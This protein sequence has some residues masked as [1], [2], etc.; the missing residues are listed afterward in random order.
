VAIVNGTTNGETLNGTQ[1]ADVISG[2]GGN[3]WLYGNGGNDTIYAHSAG[4]TSFYNGNARIW[5]GAGDDRIYLG[6][7]NVTN[8]AYGEQGADYIEGLS[9]NDVIDGGSENDVIFGGGGADSLYGGTGDDDITMG[10]GSSTSPSIV[11]G[12]YGNDEM[13]LGYSGN[14]TARGGQGDD[15]FYVKQPSWGAASY[16]GGT[17]Y[18]E[19]IAQASNIS[20]GIRAIT[21]V[22]K[23][24]A[25]INTGV[26]I[27]AYAGSTPLDFTAVN[28][29]GIV[30]INGSS[31]DN[32]VIYLAGKNAGVDDFGLGRED[33]VNAGGGDDTIYGGYLDDLLNGDAGN[34]L[35]YGDEGDDVISAG[36][37]LDGVSGGDGLDILTGGAGADKFIFSA[38]HDTDTVTDFSVTE[39]DEL[40]SL[41]G[42]VGIDDFT[43][44]AAITSQSGADTIIDFGNGDVL[45]LTGVTASSLTAS[46]FEF[47]V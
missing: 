4:Y 28:L 24:T 12:G 45:T 39:T 5:G 17:E 11:D 10:Y 36:D 13:W 14:L 29:G 3:D 37:G 15:K 23:V 18:D 35:L 47:V 44:L 34:D 7:S 40:I 27:N 2:K 31:N 1:S 8:Y 43:D 38:G 41:A 32:N 42:F 25:G 9:S 46:E 26:T 33:T 6:N 16:D 22:E 21:G 30:A 20:I 19:I